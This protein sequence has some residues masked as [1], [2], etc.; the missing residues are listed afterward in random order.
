MSPEP[1]LQ[2]QKDASMDCTAA[3]KCLLFYPLVVYTD[4][5]YASLGRASMTGQELSDA[6]PDS[7]KRPFSNVI[8]NPPI[9]STI[10][11]AEYRL[12]DYLPN[13]ILNSVFVAY[14]RRPDKI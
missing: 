11:G 4:Q 8:A 1:V 7:G 9:P 3:D 12:N 13:S 14:T 2:P 10:P 6:C 5:H